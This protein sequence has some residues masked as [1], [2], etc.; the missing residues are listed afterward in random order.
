MFVACCWCLSFVCDVVVVLVVR[1]C[2]CLS[3]VEHMLHVFVCVLM[4]SWFT[5]VQLFLCCWFCQL[6]S[7]GEADSL[8]ASD[9]P[10]EIMS[11]MPDAGA[12]EP[13]PWAEKAAEEGPVD[14]K[15]D[16]YSSSLAR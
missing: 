2:V 6:R 10:E 4:I 3:A 14:L 13:E 1:V 11:K 15:E 9:M 12:A 16:S 8:G 7:L 5:C